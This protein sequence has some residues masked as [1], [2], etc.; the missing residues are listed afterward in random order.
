MGDVVEQRYIAPSV[1]TA[2]RVLALLSRYRTR[3]STLSEITAAL[4]V[5]KAT[6]LRVLKTLETH[7]LVSFDPQTKRYS[8]GYYCVVLG[9]R[10]EEG[11]DYLQLVTPLLRHATGLT[12]LTSAFVQR[13]SADRMMYVAKVEGDANAGINVSV[14]NRFPI[15]EVSYGTWVVAYADEPERERILAGGLRAVTPRTVTDPAAYLRRAER[16]LSEGVLVSQSEYVL[17]VTAVSCPVLDVRRDLV[18][19]LTVLGL[20]EALQGQALETVVG[21]MRDVCARARFD[22]NQPEQT[23]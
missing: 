7:G 13:V 8:L 15:T 9:S 20:T 4:D 17:G 21:H 12:G 2:A 5:S 3:T 11:L 22:D 19:V 23:A 10:A 18:G 6:C 1:D 14:G 16:A